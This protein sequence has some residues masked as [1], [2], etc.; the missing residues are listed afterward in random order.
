MNR[1]TCNKLLNL[2]TK[3]KPES[4]KALKDLIESPEVNK[5]CSPVLKE[6]I[7]LSA[8]KFKKAGTG[9]GTDNI[10]INIE[11]LCKTSL[12]KEVLKWKKSAV[13]QK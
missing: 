2:L 3:E 12:K 8:V 7:L 5:Y 11:D 9:S 1:R 13:S 6:K 4:F 10:M